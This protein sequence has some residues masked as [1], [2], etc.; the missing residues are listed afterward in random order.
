M[1][2]GFYEA[3]TGTATGVFN[4]GFAE[5]LIVSDSQIPYVGRTVFDGCAMDTGQDEVLHFS[6]SICQ[7]NVEAPEVRPFASV[8]QFTV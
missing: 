4:D 2:A 8:T 5:F 6:E 3:D 1:S 7:K